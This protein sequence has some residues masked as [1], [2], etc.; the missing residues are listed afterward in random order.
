[1]RGHRKDRQ[2]KKS[3]NRHCLFVCFRDFEELRG[4]C[5]GGRNIN[6]LRYADDTAL[7][8]DNSQHLQN[9]MN[10]AKAGSEAKGLSMN[11]RKN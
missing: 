7:L 10:A 9:L 11:V 1:M 2:T 3:K 8:A 5:I 6:N 4:V